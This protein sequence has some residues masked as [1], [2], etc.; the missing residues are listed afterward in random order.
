MVR[1]WLQL[2]AWWFPYPVIFVCFTA[3]QVHAKTHSSNAALQAD[4]PEGP[5]PKIAT[6]FAM[7][8]LLDMCGVG[9]QNLGP[10]TL[11]V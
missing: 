8:L 3:A 4:K 6:V 9:W 11:K 10:R 7:A 2:A 5:A 1:W